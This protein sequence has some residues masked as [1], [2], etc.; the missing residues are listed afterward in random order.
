MSN[1]PEATRADIRRIGG[2]LSRLTFEILTVTGIGYENE[3]EPT[4]K[5]LTEAM[6]LIDQAI[7]H[8][9]EII[10]DDQIEE[11]GVNDEE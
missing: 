11:N 10:T 2:E 3:D 1:L 6:N 9:A 4:Q 8:M 7:Q 5:R